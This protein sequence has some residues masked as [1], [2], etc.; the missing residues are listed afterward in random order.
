MVVAKVVTHSTKGSGP[1]W[2][3]V[4]LHHVE[5]GGVTPPRIPQRWSCILCK[6]LHL[7]RHSSSAKA[8]LFLTLCLKLVVHVLSWTYHIFRPHLCFAFVWLFP[9]LLAY[10]SCWAGSLSIR[11]PSSYSSTKHNLKKQQN[12]ENISG[13]K[14]V[15]LLLNCLE[16]NALF[17]AQKGYPPWSA[18]KSNNKPRSAQA[19][20]ICFRCLRRFLVFSSN[21]DCRENSF[22]FQQRTRRRMARER[23]GAGSSVVSIETLSYK[24]IN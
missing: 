21:L 10:V 2:G 18:T 22:P 11:L 7:R 12:L 13:S 3:F 14:R 9:E 5:R 17:R 20:M 4:P 24:T 23:R 16:K 19:I 1:V 8:A 6:W 15:D